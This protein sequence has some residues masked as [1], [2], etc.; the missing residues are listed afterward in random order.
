[1]PAAPPTPVSTSSGAISAHDS[2][3]I[4]RCSTLH[5]PDQPARCR[6]LVVYAH[7]A[8]R[9]SR[10]SRRLAEAAAGIDG[11]WV[12]DLYETWPEFHIDAARE[13]RLLEQADALVLLYPTHWHAPPALLKE[14]LDVVLHDAWQGTGGRDAAQRLPRQ[15]WIVTSSGSA[16][17]DYSA[18]GRHGHDFTQVLA[19]LLATAHTC[20]M[21]NLA[22][23]VL[24][25]AHDID[26]ASVDAHQRRF[27]EGLRALLG[28]GAASLPLAAERAHGR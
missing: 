16:A 21:R 19:P 27:E 5:E 1:M 18:S 3:D 24:H 11:V 23:L 22:P 20:G 8:P 10:I 4:D 7:P 26:S 28:A 13:R 2:F 12:D 25:G 9:G 14:W 17:A 15:C 6:I